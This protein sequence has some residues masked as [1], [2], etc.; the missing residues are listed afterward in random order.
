MLVRR[1]S[2]SPPL[3]S[4]AASLLHSFVAVLTAVQ[5]QPHHGAVGATS[6]QLVQAQFRRASIGG[7]IRGPDGRVVIAF[8]ETADHWCIGVVEARALTR[9]LRLALACFM[10]RLVVEGD[11]LV[12]IQLLR[13]EETQTRIPAAVHDEIVTLLGC[14]AEVEVQHIY[15]E[16]NQVADGL[17]R[18]AYRYPGVWTTAAYLSPAVA[19]KVDEDRRG[20]A[21]ERLCKPRAGVTTA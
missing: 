11:D 16:G 5:A 8:A 6:R 17:C 21:H 12:L 7:A 19:E 10:E 2:A 13:G 9:G 3:R 18:Q 20:V 15:R 4:S 14:F 1:I